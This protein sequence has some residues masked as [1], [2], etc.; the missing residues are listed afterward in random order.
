[1]GNKYFSGFSLIEVLV[2]VSILAILAAVAMP[3]YKRYTIASNYMKAL[4]A[5]EMLMDKSILYSGVHGKFAAPGDLGFALQATGASRLNIVDN[6]QAAQII[7]SIYPNVAGQYGLFIADIGDYFYYL[8]LPYCGAMG[9][10]NVY[11]DAEKIGFSS[12]E[13]VSER[14]QI[15][16]DF[17]HTA[18][19]AIKKSCTYIYGTLS[20]FGTAEIVPG[21]KN[22]NAPGYQRNPVQC[23]ISGLCSYS[24]AT[25]Q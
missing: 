6:A 16:C 11:L 1:M 21:L 13:S 23:A 18:S 7:P 5:V 9:N 19:G 15:S 10:V 3:A 22:R 12:S 20:A 25:C 17:W 4:R 8:S 14:T 24:E 2:V